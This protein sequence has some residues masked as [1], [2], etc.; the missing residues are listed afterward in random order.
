M[1]TKVE[2]TAQAMTL[3]E[4]KALINQRVRSQC[5]LSLQHGE[6]IES[7]DI[8]Y[9]LD[10]RFGVN[11]DILEYEEVI[12]PCDETTEEYNARLLDMVLDNMDNFNPS[13]PILATATITFE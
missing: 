8:S 2:I 1:S 9:S 13:K 5:E 3:E 7:L 11:T 4:A 12:T 10:S 6:K